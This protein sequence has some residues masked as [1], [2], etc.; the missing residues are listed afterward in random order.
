MVK[1]QATRKNC[2][3]ILSKVALASVQPFPALTSV[4]RDYTLS[5]ATNTI[6]VLQSSDTIKCSKYKTVSFFLKK[7][8]SE[9]YFFFEMKE[10]GLS[11]ITLNSNDHVTI[12]TG[13]D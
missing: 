7:D 9:V 2:G 3:M 5:P 1:L 4:M 6:F 11:R 8:Q 12:F 13:S 10:A